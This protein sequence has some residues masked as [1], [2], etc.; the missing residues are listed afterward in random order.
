MPLFSKLSSLWRNL[1]HKTQIE[2]DLDEEARSYIEMLTEEKVKSGKTPG[3]A[4]RAA[5]IEFGGIDQVKERVRDVRVGVFLETLWYD[6]RYAARSLAKS[7]GFTTVAVL[8]LALGIGGTTLIFSLIYCGMLD[9]FPYADSH[10]L[11]VLIS[12]NQLGDKG[13]ACPPLSW[14]VPAAEPPSLTR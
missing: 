6:L 5:L 11:M 12:R 9:P 13:P 1:F 10:R 3:E 4:R 8:T 7:R 14:G 2:Q